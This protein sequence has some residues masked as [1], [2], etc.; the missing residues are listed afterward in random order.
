MAFL[1]HSIDGSAKIPGIEYLPCSAVLNGIKL[2]ALLKV[3]SGLLAVAS[4][5]DVPVYVSMVEQTATPEAGTII[6]VIRIQKDLIFESTLQAEATTAKAGAK[7]AIYTD[8]LQLGAVNASAAAEI[9]GLD[10][11]AAGDKVRVRF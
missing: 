4:G 2:G 8:G 5:T 9:V 1:I 10:G 11:T 7:I 6:P 3:T